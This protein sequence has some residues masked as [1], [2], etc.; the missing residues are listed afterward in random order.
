MGEISGWDAKVAQRIR[1]INA[2]ACEVRIWAGKEP[3][4][5][6]A[7]AYLVDGRYRNKVSR[8]HS[9]FDLYATLGEVYSDAHL[10][11]MRGQTKW[12]PKTGDR[13]DSPRVPS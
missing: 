6:R 8:T 2:L 4:E 10:T 7:A 11:V 12:R 1:T 9:G 5:Q 13:H 3:G